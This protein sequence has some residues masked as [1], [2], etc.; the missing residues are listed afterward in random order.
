MSETIKNNTEQSGGEQNDFVK[1]MNAEDVPKYDPE[2]AKKLWDEAKANSGPDVEPM[3]VTPNIEKATVA[4][5]HN[6]VDPSVRPGE[7]FVGE[8]EVGLVADVEKARAMA[9]A[10]DFWA[11]NAAG[12]REVAR[13]AKSE[14]FRKFAEDAAKGSDELADQ[15]AEQA[16]KQY[17]KQHGGRWQE[18]A[19]VERGGQIIPEEP[20]EDL[21]APESAGPNGRPRTDQELAD[22]FNQHNN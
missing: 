16:G 2:G 1:A 9:E 10:A 18:G 17:D 5:S 12:N 8:V 20:V 7:Q 14:A 6:H 3:G 4:T 11:N 21:S 19:P 22:I 15:A 13:N